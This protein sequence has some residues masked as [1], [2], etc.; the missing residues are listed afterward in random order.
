M[1][2]TLITG[3]SSGI[4]LETA[5]CLAA[6][7]HQLLL[8][9][10]DSA[11]LIDAQKLLVESYPGVEVAVLATDLSEPAN[12]QKVY[13]WA[14]QQ[15]QQ[16]DC[17]VNNA[18]FGTWGLVSDM[19]LE[20]ETAM[21]QLHVTSLYRLTRLFLADMMSRDTGRIINI[22]SVSAF[23]PNPRMAT[24]G[25]T[26]S[27]VLQF[28]RALNQEL[29]E[30]GSAVRVAAVCPTPVKSTGFQSVAGMSKSN[31][32][33]SWMVVP[34]NAVAQSIA[35]HL[36]TQKDMIIPGSSLF[37]GVYTLFKRLPDR[38]QILLSGAHLK[39]KS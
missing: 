36:G 18:G 9:A 3:G 19:D 34:P 14:L 26:N 20:K 32:F 33:Q 29:K 25:A 2:T 11:E 21:I 38:W 12:T 4:G 31:L 10:I 24:Y 6:Q 37:S 13:D 16:V 30:T 39:P 7:G 1:T 17:L 22:S 8:V 5:K 28:S 35:K 15:S 23:Q 27:F